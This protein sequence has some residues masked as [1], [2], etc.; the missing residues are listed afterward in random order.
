MNAR[1]IQQRID[2]RSTRLKKMIKLKAPNFMI[3]TEKKLLQEAIEAKRD[4]LKPSSEK[5]LNGKK[6]THGIKAYRVMVRAN[7]GMV[8]HYVDASLLEL[9]ENTLNSIIQGKNKLHAG[10]LTKKKYTMMEEQ[11]YNL[12]DMIDKQIQLNK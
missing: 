8:V 12:F 6:S 2:A 4:M 5:R 7:E 9:K 3:E 1:L 11:T 10:K